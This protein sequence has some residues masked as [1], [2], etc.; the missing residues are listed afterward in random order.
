[1][2]YVDAGCDYADKRVLAQH[3]DDGH[4]RAVHAFASVKLSPSQRDHTEEAY[5]AVWALQKFSRLGVLVSSD[6]IRPY[7]RVEW[8]VKPCSIHPAFNV[9]ASRIVKLYI[10]L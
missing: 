8:D 7:V 10:S 9:S 3:D 2:T 1:M 5:A 4:D 6:Y